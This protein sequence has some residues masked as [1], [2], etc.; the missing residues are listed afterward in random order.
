MSIALGTLH[1]AGV[2]AW[3]GGLIALTVF[4]LRGTHQRVL[5][6]ILPAWSRLATLAVAWL[7]AAGLGQAVI[8]LGR[9]AALWEST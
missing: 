4:L 1:V 8:E 6:R 3:L 5:A 7:V 2:T 9:P